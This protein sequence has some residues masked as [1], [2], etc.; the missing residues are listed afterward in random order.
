MERCA[1]QFQGFV[2]LPGGWGP[3]RPVRMTCRLG[4][5]TIDEHAD[6]SSFPLDRTHA[7]EEVEVLVPRGW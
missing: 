7:E 5:V 4:A 1:R 3:T 2:W 6:L